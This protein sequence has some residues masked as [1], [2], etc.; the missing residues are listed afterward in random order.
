MGQRGLRGT[1][2]GTVAGE[3]MTEERL[4]WIDEWV[5]KV[6]P[7]EAYYG[8]MQRFM[9][10]LLEEVRRQ[11]SEIARGNQEIEQ[12]NAEL[13]AERDE[14][15]EL[16]AHVEDVEAELE[17]LRAGLGETRVEWGVREGSGTFPV[18]DEAEARWHA[19]HRDEPMTAVR[20]LV[21]EWREPEGGDDA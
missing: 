21:G 9:R 16:T 18:V 14:N 6:K 17:T 8:T 7:A 13:T 1:G 4:A 19:R 15:R 5:T 3:V 11:R 10:E 20:R 12:L 2:V